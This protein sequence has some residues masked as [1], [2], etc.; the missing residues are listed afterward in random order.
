MW[1]ETVRK[2]LVDKERSSTYE[3]K[4]VLCIETM[5]GFPLIKYEIMVL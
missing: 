4:E 5:A 3:L 1:I 2:I